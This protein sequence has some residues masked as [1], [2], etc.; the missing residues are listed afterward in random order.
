MLFAEHLQK[1]GNE[2]SLQPI[3]QNIS[4]KTDSDC[5]IIG[6]PVHAF[7]APKPVLNF[8]KKL[9][10]RHDNL[11]I[12]F[13]QTSGEP[14]AFNNAAFIRPQRIAKAKGYRVMG[15]FSYVMPYN[16]IFHHSDGMAARMWNI[17]K[18][19][20]P[21]EADMAAKL[22]SHLCRANAVQRLVSFILRIEHPA[23]PI[24]GR[25]FKVADDCIGCGLCERQCP[26]NNIKLKE[27]RP[28]FGTSCVG[29]MGCA[30]SCPKDA[31]R[32]SLLD[33]WRINGT[34][35]FDAEPASDD[36]TCKYCRKSYLKYFH[37]HE[38]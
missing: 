20:A 26:Q 22:K 8:L 28:V 6:Y 17:A 25:R 2:I 18:L 36:G 14:L 38:K 16:I 4:F 9:P 1:L 19:R 34:Y 37:K 23:M 31:I 32:I 11:P 21:F 27:G 24:I 15:G 35:H 10:V 30:F 13:I 7:N 29:C 33:G 3:H 12:Y 5:I